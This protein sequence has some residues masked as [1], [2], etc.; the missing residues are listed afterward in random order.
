[1]RVNS[2]SPATVAGL[3]DAVALAAD[4]KHVCALR[5]GGAV[6]C[7]GSNFYGELGNGQ[8]GYAATPV[9]VLGSPFNVSQ[10][11]DL[12]VTISPL[13]SGSPEA[14]GDPGAKLGVAIS[15]F[16]ITV[17]NAGPNALADL[18]I[19][20]SVTGLGN[21]QWSCEVTVGSLREPCQPASGNGDPA[22][23]VDLPINAFAD[24][25]LSGDVDPSKNF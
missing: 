13:D 25:V 2:P 9:T 24:I 3:D 17:S 5:T 20:V 7:W 14:T 8:L 10:G 21:L 16:E 18:S 6:S 23:Q 22:T 15:T 4:Y 19:S 11:S 12:S 1:N